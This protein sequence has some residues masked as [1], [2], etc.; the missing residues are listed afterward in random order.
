[1]VQALTRRWTVAWLVASGIAVNLGAIGKRY[2][3]T[4]PSQTHGTLLP[5]VEG[6][7]APTWIELAVVGGLLALGALLIGMYMKVL[8]IVE[9]EEEE[10]HA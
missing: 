3:I 9:L 1:M 8:P 4:V 10:V 2:L 6:S 5:Y 7:Y